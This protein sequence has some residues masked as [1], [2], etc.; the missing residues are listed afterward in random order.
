M[1]Q[2]KAVNL[3][4]KFGELDGAPVIEWSMSGVT[5]TVRF[6]DASKTREAVTR[7]NDVDNWTPEEK[8]A[9]GH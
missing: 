2:G 7:L 6:K 9:T 5:A 8:Q 4:T 1:W 3:S